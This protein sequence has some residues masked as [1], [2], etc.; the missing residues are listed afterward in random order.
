EGVEGEAQLER[1]AALGCHAAQGYLFSGPVRGETF[2]AFLA[3][4]EPRTTAALAGL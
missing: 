2:A 3:G 4:E 1:L